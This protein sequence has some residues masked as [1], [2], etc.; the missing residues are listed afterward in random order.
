LFFFV[1]FQFKSI[2]PVRLAARVP[3]IAPVRHVA[4]AEGV[5]V[6]GF[7]GIK[8]LAGLAVVALLG[9][10]APAATPTF[11]EAEPGG[12]R[13]LEVTDKEVAVSGTGKTAVYIDKTDLLAD[14]HAKA[15]LVVDDDDVRPAAA[16]VKLATFDGENIRHGPGGKIVMNY[17]HPDICP[18]PHAKRIYTVNGPKLTNQ[19]LV[20]VLHVLKPELFKLTDAEVAEQKKAMAEANAE[21]EKAAAADHVVGKWEVLTGTGPVEK[22]GKGSIT[23]AAKKGDAY[24]VTYDFAPGGGPAWTGVAFYKEQ[25]GD[26]LVWV[27]YGTPKTVAL[28]VY[29]IK[30]G[31]LSGKWY[32]W[33]VTGEAKHVGTEELAGPESLDGEFKI[34]SAKSPTTGAAYTGTV[35][36]KPL[37]IVGSAKD[38]QPYS[39]TYTLG[40]AKV[41]GIGIRTG[42]K[43]FVAAG[44][45]PDLNIA[46]YTIGNGSFNGDWYKLG[47]K[48]MGTAAAM[49]PSN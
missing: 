20:A 46:K 26:K 37:T 25:F 35:S 34:T 15:F 5:M 27:A 11:I 33:Y 36:I 45:G 32:P 16:G 44:A 18:D 4:R 40:A 31:T 12:K 2:A 10:S 9:A 48:E 6:R 17:R 21:A 14:P 1:S 42:D 30:G 29:D 24:P 8:W 41:Q 39:V 19:Q 13:V 23:F 49:S 43:L 38:T 47:S 22:V 28:A 7:S 3:Y